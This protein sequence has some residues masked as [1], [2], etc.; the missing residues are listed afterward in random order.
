MD[1]VTNVGH[2]CSEKLSKPMLLK[3]MRVNHGES[4]S[5]YN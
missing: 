3:I 4:K 2:I 1:Y 5:K